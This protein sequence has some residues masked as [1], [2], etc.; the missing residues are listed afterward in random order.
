MISRHDE[1]VMKLQLA[2]LAVLLAVASP[3][4]ERLQE[5][6][7]LELARREQSLIKAG[8]DVCTTS[9]SAG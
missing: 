7:D 4:Q 3:P 8:H 2:S 9:G 1:N 5:L 6:T